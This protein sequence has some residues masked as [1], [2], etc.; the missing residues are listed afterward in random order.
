MI[1]TVVENIKLNDK[2]YYMIINNKEFV[3]KAKVGQFLMVQ[4]KE[5]DYIN[6]P[7]LRRPFGICDVDYDSGDFSILYMIVGKGT[8][9]LSTFKKGSKIEF[10]PPLGNSFTI[11]SKKNV[12]LVGGGIG[13]APLYFLAKT[14]KDNNC[15]ITLYFG[16]QSEIDIVFLDKFEKVVDEIVVTTNDGSKGMKGLVTDPFIKNIDH[17][18]YVYTCGPKKMLEAVSRICIDSGRAV[19]VS[20]DERMACGLGACLGCIVY[21]KDDDGNEIQKR[22]CVEGPIFDGSKVIWESVCRG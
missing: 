13:I 16:G 3:E 22:C 7:I 21:V 4:S 19:E 15:K 11:Q 2:Y 6:D 10:S 14:L 17:Y 5:Y 18:D 8:M 12:A 20:L 9:L 1:G